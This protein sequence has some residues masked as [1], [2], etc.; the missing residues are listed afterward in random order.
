MV[1]LGQAL[2]LRSVDISEA[3]R[4]INNARTM[5]VLRFPTAQV[6]V[7][8]REVSLAIGL[9]RLSSRIADAVTDDASLCPCNSVRQCRCVVPF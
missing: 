1:T 2:R 5:R 3:R 8:Q 4:V 9:A 7:A 6:A